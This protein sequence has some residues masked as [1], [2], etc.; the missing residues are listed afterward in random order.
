MASKIEAQELEITNL[1]VRILLLENKDRGVADKSR[2]DAPI[3]GM[4]LDEGKEAAK[5]GSDDTEEMVTIATI[6]IPLAGEI[7][8]GSGSVPTASLILPTGSGVVPTASPIIPTASPNF[9]IATVATPY[10]RRKE[11][12]RDAQRMNKQIAKDAEIARIHAEEEM[13]TMINSFDRNNE[14]V[15]KYLQEYEQFVED[16]SI[17]ERIKLISDRVKYQDNCAK[18]LKYQTQ[19]RKPRSKKQKKD[20]YMALIP[21]EE[22]YV[23][24]LQVKHPIIDWAIHTEGKISYWKIIRLGGSSVSYQFFVDMLK[25]FDREDLNQLWGLVKETLNTRQASN[26]K[27]KELWVQLKRLYEPDVEDQL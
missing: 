5:R 8:T 15:V 11:M 9:T 18:V 23:E 3:K 22:V 21:I 20:Y 4:R 17:A 6:S 12:A 10:T 7:P 2:D 26:D 16:L 19:Q 1:K 25:H 14:T 24:A 27:E 13:Q